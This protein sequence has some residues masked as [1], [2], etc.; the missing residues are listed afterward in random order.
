MRAQRNAIPIFANEDQQKGILVLP[1]LRI[2]LILV[3]L[4]FVNF[5]FACFRE[6]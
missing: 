5:G 1:I 4:I 2:L 3:L 6:K